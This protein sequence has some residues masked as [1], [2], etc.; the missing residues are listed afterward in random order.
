[1][2]TRS[3]ATAGTGYARTVASTSRAAPRIRE[4]KA[5]IAIL[6]VVL[7]NCNRMWSRELLAIRR[8]GLS[9]QGLASPH[10]WRT[11]AAATDGYAKRRAAEKAQE[12][13]VRDASRR[14]PA[15]RARRQRNPV[16]KTTLAHALTMSLGLRFA[17]V[18]FTAD[19]MPLLQHS[20]ALWP[21]PP[22]APL[23]AP[24]RP[25]A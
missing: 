2:I 1:M 8:P 20:C 18:Q 6:M 15:L 10:A 12:Q 19:L 7:N 11:S 13:P 5:N 25:R 14:R 9:R 4:P 21:D 17:R 3:C 24:T 23:D 22:T 16:A